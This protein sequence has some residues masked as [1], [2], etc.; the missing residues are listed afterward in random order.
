MKTTLTL[1]LKRKTRWPLGYIFGRGG[2]CVSSLTTAVLQISSPAG[3]LSEATSLHLW[4]RRK[5]SFG[6]RF[7]LHHLELP[8]APPHQHHAPGGMGSSNST[9][10]EILTRKW[11][12][13]LLLTFDAFEHW[14]WR[15]L[16]RVPWTVRRSNPSVLKEINP[17][18]HWKDWCWS[19]STSA[20]WCKELTPWKR[21]CCWER[22]GAAGEEGDR[23]WDGGWHHW[24][25]GPES[26]Q[27]LGD[28]EGQRGLVCCTPWD[29]SQTWLSDWKT[30]QYAYLFQSK[31]KQ[32]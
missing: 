24:L 20:T 7:S 16:L 32:N 2:G 6:T 17:E 19:S 27:T 31:E 22:L 8:V 14:C 12:K 21:P 9:P 15:I 23:G 18:Y 4:A 13:D 1:K 10:N 3:N 11:D 5:Q 30:T 26:E 25:N 29:H 28:G